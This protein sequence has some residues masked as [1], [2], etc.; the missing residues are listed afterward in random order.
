MSR[1]P[2]A[3]LRAN[4]ALSYQQ[5][6][7][8][9][10]RVPVLARVVLGLFLVAGLIMTVR[11]ALVAKDAS[12]HLKLQHGFHNAQVRVWV[13]GELA[14]SGKVSGAPRKRFGFIPTDS[15]QGSLSQII[16]VRSGQHKV[17]VRIEPDDATMQEDAIGGDFAHNAERELSVSARQNR[18]SLSWLGTNIAPAET[19]TTFGWFLRYGGSLLL[20]IGGSIMSALTGYAIKAL[21][22]RL[23]PNATSPPKAEIGAVTSIVPVVVPLAS[24]A[25]GS[26]P[27]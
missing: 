15:V 26:Q 5:T 23:R 4:T 20:T 24:N 27:N 14:Y 25:A 9:A 18:L 17:R 8:W 10:A 19:S 21:Y 2:I 11:T 6:R 1:E 12:L 3:L 22:A 16:P 7:Q 13:D